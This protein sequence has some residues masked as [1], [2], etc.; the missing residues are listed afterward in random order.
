MLGDLNEKFIFISQMSMQ[1]SVNNINALLIVKE[2][3]LL[4]VKTKLIKYISIFI[5]AYKCIYIWTE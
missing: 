3:L 4:N 1:Y 5:W 2:V